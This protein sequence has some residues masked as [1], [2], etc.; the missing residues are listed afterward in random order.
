MGAALYPYKCTIENDIIS[1][2]TNCKMQKGRL[3][4]KLIEP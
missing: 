1:I 3:C 2:I 4:L